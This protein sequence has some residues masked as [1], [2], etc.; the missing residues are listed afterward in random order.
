MSQ[1]DDFEAP[2][3]PTEEEKKAF[4]EFAEK[5]RLAFEESKKKSLSYEKP[6]SLYDNFG[7]D[8]DNVLNNTITLAGLLS[9]DIEKPIW[10]I[11]GI[12][13]EKGIGIIGGD[14]GCGKSLISINIADCISTGKPLFG[15]FKTVKG[16]VLI[17]DKENAET[18][19]QQRCLKIVKKCEGLD[20]VRFVIEKD[21]KLDNFSPWFQRLDAL[22][23]EF[24]PD[25][26]II[27]SAV[28]FID[29]DENSSKDIRK[30]YEFIR[31]LINKHNVSWILLHHLRKGYGNKSV[32]DLRGSGDFGA[33]V[34]VIIMVSKNGDVLTVKQEKNRHQKPLCPFKVTFIDTEEGDLLFQYSKDVPEEVIK[35][36]DKCATAIKKWVEEEKLIQIT[37][38]QTKEKFLRSDEDNDEIE[39]KFANNAI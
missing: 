30:I 1:W 22:I 16:K 3:K 7:W 15:K 27:D 29:G 9:K 24:N 13:P 31:P 8:E 18:W 2:P 5:K 26:I 11:E 35:E 20:D 39:D 25:V 6:E 32:N 14:V 4:F 12:L 28:R 37:T 36:Y 10:N 17:I 23:S 38:K 19:I 21:V 34:D 33:F